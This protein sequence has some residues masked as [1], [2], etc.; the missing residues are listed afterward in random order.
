MIVADLARIAATKRRIRL[1]TT[2][3]RCSDCGAKFNTPGCCVGADRQPTHTVY[4][5]ATKG[6]R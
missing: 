1:M 5:G 3:K 6:T 2:G 4:G